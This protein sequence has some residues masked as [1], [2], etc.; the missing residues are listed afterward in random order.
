MRRYLLVG[1][2]MA[3]STVTYAVTVYDLRNDW[4]DAVN[5][6]G[7][8]QYRA[9]TTDLVHAPDWTGSMIG[10]TQPVWTVTSTPS[11]G[12]L[13]PAV[14]KATGTRAGDDYAVGDIIMH[15]NSP[16]CGN[17]IDAANVAWTAPFGG[18]INISGNLWQTGLTTGP[19]A[20]NNTATLRL[21]GVTLQTIPNLAGFSSASPASVAVNSLA[22][23][24]GDVVSLN[25]I[26]D[27]NSIGYL[28]DLN[29]H[30]VVSNASYYFSHIAAA[31]VWR[32]TFT[33]VNTSTLPV[34]CNT[35]FYS[36]LGSPLFLVFGGNS[37]SSTIDNI[38]AGGTA[39]RQTDAQ[40]GTSVVTGWARADCTG[41]VKASALFRSYSGTTPKAEG[42]VLAMTAPA[43]RFVT[44]SDQT[45][46]VAW[47]NPSTGIAAVTFT[48]KDATGNV[49]GT[50]TIM[51]PA[52]YHSQANMG[53]LLNISSFQGSITITSSA[54]I[55]TL[56][57]NFEAAPIFSALPPG[58]DP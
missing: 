9:G 2:L 51:V 12:A 49:I 35:F 15:S 45:T 17:D 47:A 40:P 27:P 50:N 7:V 33:Y 38:P 4:S 26:R 37:V 21:N 43:T 18:V 6:N 29:L 36:D 42:A 55:I 8:W 53:I 3:C 1:F 44:Y 10:Y 34:T 39:R 28:V 48:A 19:L 20:R 31:D 41:P 32:S 13:C 23:H 5:P 46:G 58:Q 14:G 24:P 54:P 52:G 57:L 16:S 25:V 22:V 56:S 11:P 30:I